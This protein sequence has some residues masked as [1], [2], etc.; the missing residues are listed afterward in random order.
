MEK[1]VCIYVK[2]RHYFYFF[3]DLKNIEEYHTDF[4]IIGHLTFNF[5]FH[6]EHLK[7]S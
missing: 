4:L 5:F 1:L 6:L 7:L 2:L 3:L